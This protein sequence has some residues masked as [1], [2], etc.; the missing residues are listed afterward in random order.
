MGPNIMETEGVELRRFSGW[1]KW[2]VLVASLIAIFFAGADFVK[3]MHA[4]WVH[5]TS[6]AIADPPK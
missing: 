1:V 3:N 5:T 2:V 6:V 4:G